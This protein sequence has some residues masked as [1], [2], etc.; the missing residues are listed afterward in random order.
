MTDYETLAVILS[1]ISAIAAT[2][3]AVAAKRLFSENRL[4]SYYNFHN[5]ISKHHTE[6]LTELRRTVRE[7][8]SSK[9]AEAKKQHKTLQDI[10]PNFHLKVS[11]LANYY[12]S[13]GMFLQGGWRFFPDE[14]KETMMQLLHNSVSKHWP[15]INE[16]KSL[17]HPDRPRDWAQSFQWLYE[18]VTEYRKKHGL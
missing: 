2:V 8:L 16:Y 4:L 11:T 7:Q 12:E 9:A 13:I 17:I 1:A 6:E 15:E 10:D 14:V 3:A 18:Q 5:I